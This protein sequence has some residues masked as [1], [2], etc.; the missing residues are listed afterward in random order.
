MLQTMIIILAVVVVI[1]LFAVASTAAKFVD[2][3]RRLRKAL[4]ERDEERQKASER[5]EKL[6]HQV[7]DQGPRAE[8]VVRGRRQQTRR[9]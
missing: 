4:A 7:L 5:E 2:L 3:S 8:P 1:G 9:L 6:V